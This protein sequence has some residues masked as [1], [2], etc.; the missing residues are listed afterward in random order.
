MMCFE[1]ELDGGGSLL[2]G[3]AGHKGSSTATPPR[4]HQTTREHYY[5]KLRD[6]TP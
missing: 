6:K 5:A 1:N 2:S 3:K 4:D